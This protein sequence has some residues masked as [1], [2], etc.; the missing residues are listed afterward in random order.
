MT[1][2]TRKS[3]KLKACPR[4]GGD[5][6]RMRDTFGVYHQCAQCGREIR[7]VVSMPLAGDLDNH[8]SDNPHL[9]N[10][11]TMGAGA[12]VNPTERKGKLMV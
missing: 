8:R 1:T 4:C 6:C 12:A 3:L 10:G 11:Q 2:A 7:P 5:V 9:D